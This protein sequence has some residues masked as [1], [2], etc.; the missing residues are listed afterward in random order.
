MQST[1]NT[2]S[3][4]VLTQK[5]K[6][7]NEINPHIS[8]KDRISRKFSKGKVHAVSVYYDNSTNSKQSVLEYPFC[9][10]GFAA[11]II[12]AYNNHQHLRLSPD[13]VWLTIS[14]GVSRHINYNAEK[15]RKRFVKH[16]GKEKVLINV[17]DILGENPHEK[18]LEAINR[19]VTETDKRVEK[20]D[21]TQLLECD[22]STTTSIS[23]TASRIVLLDMVKA[24]FNFEM[25]CACGIPKVTLE[26]TLED[27]T[28]LQEKV[29]K[30]RNLNLELDFWL[31]RLEPVILKLIDTYRGEIDEEFWSKVMSLR[32]YG[33]GGEA[34]ISGWISAFFPYDRTG[35]ALHSNSLDRYD[36][37]DGVVEVP[38]TADIGSSF[39]LKFVAGFIGTNQEIIEYLGNEPV[40][41]PVIGWTVIDDVKGFF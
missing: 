36:I 19:L 1:T 31:N 21:L 23:L 33:S 5:I 8:I 17:D 9:S 2:H 26:G 18:T 40:V 41:S 28:K 6:L 4:Q 7:E 11:A 14:Q 30:L 24:Y 13:D 27:W 12:H 15:F 29:I 3:T 37:P 20:I 25:V 35:Q 32:S 34:T 38:F 39:S 16:E 22:F 10:N